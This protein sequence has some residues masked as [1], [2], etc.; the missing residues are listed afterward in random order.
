MQPLGCGVHPEPSRRSRPRPDPA[1]S[2]SSAQPL[3]GRAGNLSVRSWHGRRPGSS[4]TPQRNGLLRRARSRHSAIPSSSS[5]AGTTT[6]PTISTAP[7]LDQFAS[8]L[9]VLVGLMCEH[10]DEDPFVTVPGGEAAGRDRWVSRTS[11]YPSPQAAY[12]SVRVPIVDQKPGTSDT[13]RR[14]RRRSARDLALGQRVPPVLYPE[15][16][17]GRQVLRPCR[18]RRPRAARAR[19]AHRRVDSDRAVIELQAGLA[20]QLGPRLTPDAI[21]ITPASI[22]RS[23]AITV[24]ARC[25]ARSFDR[26]PERERDAV[27]TQPPADDRAAS[28]PSRAAL[29]AD[30]SETSSTGWPRIR[31]DAA[32]S[33][34]MNP[35]PITVTGVRRLK[36]ASSS[37]TWSACAR[38]G[39]AGSS[40][41]G[42][43][44]RVGSAP[45]ASRQCS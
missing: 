1:E 21:T 11:S 41:P 7:P 23:P 9:V 2:S 13:R 32:I 12:L 43:G 30:S 38:P 34:P 22:R 29:G 25:P 24:I 18:R 33:H 36:R 42:I 44:S 16:P 10:A 20:G 8:P 6:T 14:H 27:V 4:R 45:V 37:Q 5:R 35:E 31:S 3:R 26:G 28:S 15:R 19:G 39:R 40:T 17:P